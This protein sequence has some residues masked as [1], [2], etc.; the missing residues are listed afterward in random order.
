MLKKQTSVL[1]VTLGVK[2]SQNCSLAQE[3]GRPT[4][5]SHGER[6]RK[7]LGFALLV[8]IQSLII[9]AV[10]ANVTRMAKEIDS[11]VSLDLV[12]SVQRICTDVYRGSQTESIQNSD[13]KW[14]IVMQ[15][16]SN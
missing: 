1:Q 6:V 7:L 14:E 16:A 15:Q 9:Y 2:G 12:A 10:Q 11:G 3:V 8:K 5:G 4:A 13:G